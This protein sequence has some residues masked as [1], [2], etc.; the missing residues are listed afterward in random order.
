MIL[1]NKSKLM[2]DMAL[3]SIQNQILLHPSSNFKVN[4]YSYLGEKKTLNLKWGNTESENMG[5]DSIETLNAL[6]TDIQTQLD[7][8]YSQKKSR[9]FE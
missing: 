5:I 1:I 2:L 9:L 7:K 8:F 3:S 4:V 6:K